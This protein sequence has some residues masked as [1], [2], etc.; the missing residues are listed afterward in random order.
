M[1]RTEQTSSSTQGSLDSARQLAAALLSERGEASG[2][3]IA[4]ELQ[5]TLRRLDTD[6]RHGFQRYLATT[7]QPDATKLRDAATRYLA[8]G[9]A[10]AAAAL[11]EAADPPR[12][13]V[14]RRMNT[15]P[16]GTATL[17]AM[18]SEI[19]RRLGAEPELKLL[20]ADLKH[21]FASWFNRGFLE[22]RRIDWDSP[23]A[24]LE[25]LIA[26]EAVHEIKG[27]DD[28]RRRL[29]PDRRCFAFF[30]PALPGEPLIFVEVALVD[31]LATAVP[32][33]LVQDADEEA[34]RSRAARADTAIFYSISNCQD[35]LRGV[36]FGNFLIKQVVEELQTE[37]PQLKRFSTL[38]PIPGFRRW[39][40]QQQ[41]LS[42]DD[43]AMLH[44]LDGNGWWRDAATQDRV[45]SLLMKQCALYLTRSPVSGMRVDPVA[46][47][48]LGN[49][50]R[51]ER[52]NWLGNTADRAMAESFGIMVNYL[53]DHDS[54][55]RNHEAFAREGEI[56]RSPQVDALL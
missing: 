51:L 20:D 30:H 18:R 34:A 52:I 32:P 2:A 13:E 33:L 47:F 11:A 36:S 44:A 46:R 43:T 4:R 22:L 28:L 48:H 35:G 19:A 23:A 50:A 9:T 42:A 37:F 5:Q 7:F 38:S 39:L 31:G 3:S 6:G 49:G 1:T 24:V 53:Y 41:D 40:G 16:G 12:Q 45:R 56:V 29:A 8:D 27:W 14:L 25:K 15:A 54:I 21:L 55:E 10:A 26:Y 17:V